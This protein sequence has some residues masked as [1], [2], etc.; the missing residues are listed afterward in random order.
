MTETDSGAS[1]ESAE[2]KPRRG[3]RHW[4]RAIPGTGRDYLLIFLAAVDVVLIMFRNTFEVIVPVNVSYGLI[5]YDFGVLTFW[6]IDFFFFFFKDK[7]RVSFAL[8]HWYEIVGLLPFSVL[9]VFL[10]L[11]AA[12]LAIAYYKLGRAEQDV[13]RMVTREL[14]FRFRDVIIDTI[15]DGIFARSLTRV[16][17]VMLRLDYPTLS[18]AAL[19]RHEPRIR[20]AVSETLQSRSFTAELARIPFMNRVVAMMGSDISDI[21]VE[22]LRDD[23]IG[24]V[25]HDITEAVLRDMHRNLKELDLERLTRR[26]NGE[27]TAAAP[28]SVAHAEAEDKNG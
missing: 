3:L 20:A 2:P 25:F 21:V 4:L 22:I 12:K 13:S 5:A 8:A 7:A 11:R 16:E 6:G 27:S 26:D 24:D 28:D 17:E 18:R 14:T 1:A 10:L 19:E 23:L 15:A 9:R